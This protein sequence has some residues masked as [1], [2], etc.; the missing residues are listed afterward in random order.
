MR[1]SD[2][3]GAVLPPQRQWQFHDAC[4]DA[5]AWTLH[6]D[7]KRV[8]IENKPLQLLRCLL[9]R[10]GSVVRKGELLDAVWPGVTV[11][12]ASLPTAITKLRRALKDSDGRIVETVPGIGY[13]LAVPVKTIAGNAPAGAAAAAEPAVVPPPAVP[14]PEIPTHPLRRAAVLVTAWLGATGLAAMLA[15]AIVDR[16][17]ATPVTQAEARQAL[18]RL[19]LNAVRQL[20]DRGWSPMMVFDNQRNDALN[21]VLG[22]CEWN[23]GHDHK[24][25]EQMVWLL[26]GDGARPDVRNVWGDTAYSIA[27]AKRYCGPDHP[28]TRALRLACSD[29]AGR[30]RPACLPDYEHSDWPQDPRATS[31]RSKMQN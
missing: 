21:L 30:L 4:F 18:D 26:L 17:P 22:I 10:P 23:P 16:R 28:V 2:A 24:R 14:A 11:V 20:T 8:A 12:E 31:L 5:V 27:A 19:D 29:A 25:L 6:V 7:G 3:G 9:E 15:L 1:V 13:R